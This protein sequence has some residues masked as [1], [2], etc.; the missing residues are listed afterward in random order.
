MSSF[1]LERM[2]KT[3]IRSNDQNIWW[4]GDFPINDRSGN[5][6]I[7]ILAYPKSLGELRHIYD[8]SGLDY[9]NDYTKYEN[10]NYYIYRKNI[11]FVASN[12]LQDFWFIDKE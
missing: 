1:D 2:D 5:L 7:L 12:F 4:K 9:I 6:K 11:G 8:F 3:H 10:S